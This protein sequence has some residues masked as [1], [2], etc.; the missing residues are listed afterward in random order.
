MHSE[1]GYEV[2]PVVDAIGG[3]SLEHR[4]GLERVVAAGGV[5]ISWV[6]LA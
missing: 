6:S 2:C 5:P 3:T 1:R 4:A